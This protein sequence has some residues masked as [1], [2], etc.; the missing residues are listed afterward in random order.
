MREQLA[1]GAS[2]A[3]LTGERATELSDELRRL[4]EELAQDGRAV[5]AVEW[6]VQP[7]VQA[8]LTEVTERR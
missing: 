1:A 7:H 6:E 3:V 8:A 5:R 2:V 4:G